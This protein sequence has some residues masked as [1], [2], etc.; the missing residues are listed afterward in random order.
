VL[1]GYRY[2]SE[3]VA[4]LVAMIISSWYLPAD[5]GIIHYFLG[6]VLHESN[7]N[8]LN[9]TVFILAARLRDDQLPAMGEVQ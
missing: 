7:E 6:E 2:D 8:E 4:S 3:K 5:L 9:D 1:P